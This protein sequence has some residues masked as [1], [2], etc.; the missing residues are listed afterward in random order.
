MNGLSQENTS[1]S[2]L[3]EV[4][5][6]WRQSTKG[7][8]YCMWGSLP[9]DIKSQLKQED[10]FGKTL[11]DF[12][13]NVKQNQ[14]GGFIVFRNTKA[15]YEARNKQQSFR[16]IAYR[17]VE[18]QALPIEEAN[19]LLTAAQ[20]YELVG[21]DPVKILNGELLIIICKKEMKEDAK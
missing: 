7:A 19:K 2:S 15:E 13:Y 8:I 10:K 20:D 11:G 4:Q 18:V 21:T 14:D 6:P 9:E 16:K 3:V 12:H 1:L 17:T 5:P